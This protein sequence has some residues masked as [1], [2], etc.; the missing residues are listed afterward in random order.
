VFCQ[1]LAGWPATPAQ[2]TAS[3]FNHLAQY[4]K[5]P[6]SSPTTR[7]F[8]LAVAVTIASI[9]FAYPQRDDQADLARVARLNTETLTL[10]YI[11]V[12]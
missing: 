4:A 5:S 12:H 11:I 10:G 9:H 8:S 2:L 3:A 7:R 6:G 1:F